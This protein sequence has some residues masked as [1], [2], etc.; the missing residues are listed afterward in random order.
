[1]RRG[2]PLS[3]MKD[4]VKNVKM[5]HEH[6][7]NSFLLNIDINCILLS[8]VIRTMLIQFSVDCLNGRDISL[9]KYSWLLFIFHYMNFE[10]WILTCFNMGAHLEFKF[11]AWELMPSCVS[12][13]DTD[14][15]KIAA[16][17]INTI[18]IHSNWLAPIPWLIPRNQLG[19]NIW[20]M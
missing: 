20:K 13:L 3:K 15:C 10:L 19:H 6:W 4:I 18:I 1:M 2:F 7:A 9:S 14:T 12:F 17:Y 5:L 16:V 8:V 11:L